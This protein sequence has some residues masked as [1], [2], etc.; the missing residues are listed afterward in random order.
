MNFDFSL[1]GTLQKKTMEKKYCRYLNFCERY[2]FCNVHF[3]SILL[4]FVKCFAAIIYK[5]D[6]SVWWTKRIYL[7]NIVRLQSNIVHVA[8]H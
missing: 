3:L 6:A 8:T 1:F 4:F 2:F 7:C 5:K